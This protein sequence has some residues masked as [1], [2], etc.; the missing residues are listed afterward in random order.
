[1]NEGIKYLKEGSIVSWTVSIQLT[2]K[3]VSACI[4]WIHKQRVGK[5]Q[6]LNKKNQITVGS[7]TQRK[8]GELHN[9]ILTYRNTSSKST[10]YLNTY[11]S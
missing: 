10:F 3:T 1:M 5:K 11:L 6:I 9:I 2:T 7:L 4:R 8:R